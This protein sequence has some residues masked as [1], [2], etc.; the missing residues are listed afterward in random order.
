MR[1]FSRL[2]HPVTG[3]AWITAQQALHTT[4]CLTSPAIFV[5]F[6]TCASIS[7]CIWF[8]VI[9]IKHKKPQPTKK[10]KLA[11]REEIFD[12]LANESIIWILLVTQFSIYKIKTGCT[13]SYCIIRDNSKHGWK[14]LEKRSFFCICKLFRF[15]LVLC[16]ILFC[17]TLFCCFPTEFLLNIW[18]QTVM[19]A[20]VKNTSCFS[21]MFLKVI[22]T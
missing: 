4:H 20:E 9:D 3:K 22:I 17:W 21:C 13:V 18:R 19:F 6:Y 12:E 14:W 5:G 7:S 10:E 11:G 8:H 16:L 15:T 2:G 1:H